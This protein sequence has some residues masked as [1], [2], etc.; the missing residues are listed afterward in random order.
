LFIAHRSGV[1]EPASAMAALIAWSCAAVRESRA[2]QRI[3]R[4]AALG[5]EGVSGACTCIHPDHVV[6]APRNWSLVDPHY[7]HLGRDHNLIEDAAVL[8]GGGLDQRLPAESKPQA[9]VVEERQLSVPLRMSRGRVE[10]AH[11]DQRPRALSADFLQ[12]VL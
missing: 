12:L 7:L 5:R 8:M 10:V 1:V 2:F 6:V 11:E 4:L 9:E 3:P